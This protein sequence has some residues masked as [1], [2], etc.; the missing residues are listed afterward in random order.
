MF[1]LW[2]AVN[3]FV[4]PELTLMIMESHVQKVKE[5]PGKIF[6]KLSRNNNRAFLDFFHVEEN[7][8]FEC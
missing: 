4:F 3:E 5:S 8:E 7:P 1:F 6:Q 2:L